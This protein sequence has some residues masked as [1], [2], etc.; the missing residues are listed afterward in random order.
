MMEKSRMKYELGRQ[1][2]CSW[3]LQ[4]DVQELSIEQELEVLNIRVSSEKEMSRK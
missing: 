3:A 4:I 1:A 2:F